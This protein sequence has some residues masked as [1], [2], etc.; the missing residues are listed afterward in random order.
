MLVAEGWQDYELIDTG[1]GEKLERWGKYVLRRPDPQAL[2]A[3]EDSE[4]LW[5]NA[6]AVYHRSDQGGGYWEYRGTVP[7][8]WK[9]EYGKLIFLVQPMQ[10]KHTGV[11]PEQAVNWDWARVRI[12]REQNRRRKEGRNDAIE[13]L[14][15]FAYTG[16]AT[17]AAVSV[18]AR[19]CHVD[20]SKGMILKAKE[21]I[22]ASKLSN[23]LTRFIVDDVS[24]FVRREIKRKRRY[25]AIIMDP[26]AYGRGPDGEL[27]KVEN[28]LFDLIRL[29][30]ELLSREPLF[31][32]V[33]SYASALSPT[34]IGNFLA[35]S[36]GSKN[37]GL[38]SSDEIGLKSS[39][40]GL[41]LPCGCCGRW[42]AANKD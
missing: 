22:T 3:R 26:P 35:L 40:R 29:C 15:L 30:S 9:I 38:V 11:F 19:V 21:N 5:E 32:I 34:T 31:M 28:Q 33:S 27:W 16:G 39:L 17:M 4:T 23:E 18:G 6:D 42:E 1:F 8:R 10:F 7:D 12:G 25:D 14:N 24:K 37:G 2:W 41:T 13:I 20:A 36:V